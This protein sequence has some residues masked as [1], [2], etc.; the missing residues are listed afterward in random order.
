[1]PT[2][3]ILIAVVAFIAGI[4][5]AS[6][7]LRRHH[8]PKDLQEAKQQLLQQEK[9]ASIGMLTA[10]IAHEIKNPLN[11]INNFSEMALELL[12]DLQTELSKTTA[13]P[14]DTITSMINDILTNCEKIK[15]HGKRAESIVKNMLI[16]A[17]TSE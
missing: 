4:G 3:T 6:L 10:G 2:Q 9:M 1:M 17:R 11:F 15:E 7:L 16:Q 5:L 8:A 12:K 14:S 13:L